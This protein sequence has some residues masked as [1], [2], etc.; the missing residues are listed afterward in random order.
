MQLVLHGA[1]LNFFPDLRAYVERRLAYALIRCKAL[2]KEA[3][4]SLKNRKSSRLGAAWTCVIRISLRGRGKFT[5]KAL[6]SL[7]SESID[8]AIAL[9]GEDLR[10]KLRPKP[11]ERRAGGSEPLAWAEPSP[12]ARPRRR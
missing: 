6:N 7:P 1:Y 3:S 8:D 2:V 10:R 4:V 12:V 5:A 9:L 11:A